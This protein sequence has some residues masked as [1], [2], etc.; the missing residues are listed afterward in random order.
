MDRD[1]VIVCNEHHSIFPG[2]LLFW[3]NHTEDS[4]KRSFAGY[5]S[6]I[7][8]C[9]RYTRKELEEWRGEL[10]DEYPFFEEISAKKFS[11]SDEVLITIEQLKA[12]GYREY[13]VMYR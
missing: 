8:K 5:T 11:R 9:E 7:D 4:E 6:K 10:K 1:Y 13:H 2:A 3:G 12:L